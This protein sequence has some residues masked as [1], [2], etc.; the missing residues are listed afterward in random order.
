MAS[1]GQPAIPSAPAATPA[2]VKP[3]SEKKGLARV[4]EIIALEI[5]NKR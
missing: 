1:V 4:E 3:K 2:D 5:A